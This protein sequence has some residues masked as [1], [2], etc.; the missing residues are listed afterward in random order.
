[1]TDPKPATPAA[2]T[3]AK[4]SPAPTASDTDPW[5]KLAIGSICLCKD[6]SQ[7]GGGWWEARCTDIGKDGNTLIMEWRGFANLGP[8]H[9]K[10]TAVA[11]L[12]PKG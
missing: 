4:P 7:K 11:I 5:S 8:F 9:V 1:M 10:R 2:A 6:T 12:P 3:P